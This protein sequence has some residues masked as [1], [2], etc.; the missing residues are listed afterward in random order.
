MSNIRKEWPSDDRQKNATP[1]MRQM[2]E[3]NFSQSKTIMRGWQQ[4]RMTNL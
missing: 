3:N 2:G 1:E 4:A